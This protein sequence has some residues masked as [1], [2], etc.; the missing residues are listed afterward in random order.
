MTERVAPAAQHPQPV[1]GRA[2]G[3]D[4]RRLAGTGLTAD[5][6]ARPGAGRRRGERPRE[7]VELALPLEEAHGATVGRGGRAL[8]TP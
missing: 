5:R 8:Q 1:V 2:G 3:L 6:D 7:H 4:E